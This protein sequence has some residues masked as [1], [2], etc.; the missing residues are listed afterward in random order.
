[1]NTGKELGGIRRGLE[2]YITEIK[3]VCFGVLY[4]ILIEEEPDLLMSVIADLIEFTQLVAFPIQ[5]VYII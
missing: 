1:M 3:E 4:V 5:N 2:K